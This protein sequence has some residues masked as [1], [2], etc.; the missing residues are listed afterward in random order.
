[1][2]RA[3]SAQI[4]SQDAASTGLTGGSSQGD[5]R[6]LGTWKLVSC[7]GEWSDGRLTYPYGPA[8]A[9]LLVYTADGHFS[10]Q[11]QGQDRPRFESG[12]LLRGTPEEIKAAFEGYDRSKDEVQRV[13]AER[14]PIDH[15]RESIL[16]QKHASEAD[17]KEID[18]EIKAIVTEA[19]EFAQNSPEPAPSELFTDILVAS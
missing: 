10:G 9:G 15:L 1:M 3:D 17:L 19:A 18:R 13:R 2:T 11:I 5:D 16:S 8:P 4:A 12:N 7:V 14:D 6:L